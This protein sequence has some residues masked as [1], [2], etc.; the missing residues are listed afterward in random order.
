[1][2][3]VLLKLSFDGTAY[4]GWQVQNNAVTVQETL[5]DKINECFGFRPDI[6][7]CSRTDAGVHAREFCC[8]FVCNDNLP[9]NAFIRGLNS[10]L[11]SDMAVIG[12]YEVPD[13]FHARYSAKGK[14]YLYR[15]YMGI[16]DPFLER[17]A[18][19]LERKPDICLMN[20]FCE[21]VLGTHDFVGFSAKGSSVKDT[22]RNIE[23][24]L[25][26]EKDGLI[27]FDVTA[28]GFLYNMV[29]ILSGTALEVGYGRLSIDCAEQIFKTGDRSLGGNTLAA[30][31]LLLNKVYY[32]FDFGGEMSA[33][34]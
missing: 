5:Q 27:I 28:N 6:T 13:D 30:K 22:V 26:Y 25:V 33:K 24:C 31:G 1:M 14:N 3:K 17:Y 15:M 10:V 11:P 2:K 16:T 32:D 19:R 29:R 7:G 20:R 21:S 12:Y 4:H 23:R 18:L 9:E 8:H 34:L